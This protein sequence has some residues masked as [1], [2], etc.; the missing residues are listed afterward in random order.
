[1]FVYKIR[2]KNEKNSYFREK[3][4]VFIIKTKIF[5]IVR[6]L[7]IFYNQI[8]NSWPVLWSMR[9]TSNQNKEAK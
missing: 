5:D 8:V 3:Y 9:Q 6:G 2:D 4:N 7:L 1:M